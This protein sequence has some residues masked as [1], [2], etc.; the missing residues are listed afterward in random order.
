MI[1]DVIR[2]GER[3]STKIYFSREVWDE[4]PENKSPN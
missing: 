3:E 4:S 2:D 1:L